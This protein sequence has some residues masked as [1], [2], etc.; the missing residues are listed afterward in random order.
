MPK[1]HKSTVTVA[2]SGPAIPVQCV[3]CGFYSGDGNPDA[4]CP[5]C[6]KQLLAAYAA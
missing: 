6:G 1:K 2:G 5:T 4:P 3:N